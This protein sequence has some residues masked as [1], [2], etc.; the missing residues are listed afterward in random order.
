MAAMKEYVVLVCDVFD[1]FSPA[2]QEQSQGSLTP[3]PSTLAGAQ[4]I[5]EANEVLFFPLECR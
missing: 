1:E 3:A 4:S 2:S 5:S